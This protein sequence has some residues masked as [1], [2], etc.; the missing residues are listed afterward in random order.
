LYKFNVVALVLL[1]IVHGHMQ[2][3]S[4]KINGSYFPTGAFFGK[5][6][7]N[8]IALALTSSVSTYASVRSQAALGLLVPMPTFCALAR[9]YMRMNRVVSTNERIMHEIWRENIAFMKMLLVC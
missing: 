1:G 3:G 6:N 2:R 9:L 5:A 7:G 8:G 4:A